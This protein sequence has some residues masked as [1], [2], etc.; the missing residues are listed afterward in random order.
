MLLL[1]VYVDHAKAHRRLDLAA[2]VN[3]D[4]EG[5]VNCQRLVVVDMES[6]ESVA[7]VVNLMNV[8]FRADALQRLDRAVCT[9]SG[10]EVREN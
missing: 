4:G 10:G 5:P 7:N 8:L 6:V 2:C 1:V 3:S 9:S